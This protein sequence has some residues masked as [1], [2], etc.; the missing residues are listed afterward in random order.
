MLIKAVSAFTVADAKGEELD[1]G[2]M[3]RYLNEMMWFPSAFLEGNV[4]FD[5]VDSTSARVSLADH[6]TG[7]TAMMF[8]DTTAVR[9][10]WSHFNGRT[11]CSGID[12]CANAR[13]GDEATSQTA[14]D[15]ILVPLSP[16]SDLTMARTG[17]S[18]SRGAAWPAP[19]ARPMGG[20]VQDSR[21]VQPLRRGLRQ[22]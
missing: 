16:T 3:M 17:C 14:Q 19:A 12:R 8:F 22:D 18:R 15:G 1:Q 7:V 9:A 21:R 11:R 4:S 20:R 5:A 10:L 2:E 6:G 13:P